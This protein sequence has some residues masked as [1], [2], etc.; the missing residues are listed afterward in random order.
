MWGS[1]GRIYLMLEA[2]KLAIEGFSITR[3]F[4]KPVQAGVNVA[5][6]VIVNLFGFC[7]GRIDERNIRIALALLLM[8]AAALPAFAA[9][10][11]FSTLTVGSRSPM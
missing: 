10:E 8:W 4:E 9:D 1:A 3:T 2:R 7:S 11:T 5:D 6:V